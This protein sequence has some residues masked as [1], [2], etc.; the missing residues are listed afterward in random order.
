ML[1]HKQTCVAH[2]LI[3]CQPS[4]TEWPGDGRQLV[5]WVVKLVAVDAVFLLL[6]AIMDRPQRADISET[7]GDI[8]ET[9]RE[10]RERGGRGGGG[11][12]ATAWEEILNEQRRQTLAA[13]LLR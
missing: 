6:W 12:E 8:G 10:R 3:V 2:C 13:R 7:V 1:E 4:A 9:R 5:T 11:R